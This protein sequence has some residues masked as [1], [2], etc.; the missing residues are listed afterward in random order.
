MSIKTKVKFKVKKRERSKT[1]TASA[2]NERG[3][4]TVRIGNVFGTV[5]EFRLLNFGLMLPSYLRM[6]WQ[7]EYRNYK[8][9]SGQY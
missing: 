3:A 2:K 9:F 7:S 5:T 4:G 1:R 6:I 8:D